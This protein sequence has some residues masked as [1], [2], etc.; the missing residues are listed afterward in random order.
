MSNSAGDGLARLEPEELYG[1]DAELEL[2]YR[3]V[4]SA[5]E[6]ERVV[7]LT[8]EPGSGK[9]ALLDAAAR[10][11]RDAGQRVL[12]GVG[13]EFEADLAFAGLHQLLHPV[14]SEATG[15]LE[16]QRTALLG[17]VGLRPT[18]EVPKPM[19]VGIAVLTLLSDLAERGPLTVVVDDVHWMDRASQ[20]VVAFVARR[21]AEERISLLIGVRAGEVAPGFDRLQR[22][23]VLGPLD[24]GAAHRLVAA[25]AA[26]LTMRGREQII[27]QAAGNPLALQELAQA[28]AADPT[29][30]EAGSAAG[31][32]PLSDR[33]ERIYAAHLEELPQE[34]RAALV[35]LSAA[36]AADPAHDVFAAIPGGAQQW[37]PAYQAGLV[38][39]THER[40]GFRHPL[41]RTAV[42]QRATFQERRAAHL[43]LA[44]A[45]DNE[46]DRQAWHRA[47]AAIQPDTEVATALEHTADR[48]LR[49]GGYAAA[50]AALESGAALSTNRADSARLLVAAA[51]SA[52]YTGDLPWVERMASRV[53]SLT[54]DPTVLSDVSL[55]AG[56]LRAL[57]ANHDAA[58]STLT[59]LAEQALD[60]D[61]ARALD[62]LALASVVCFYSGRTVHRQVVGTLTARVAARTDDVLELWIAVVCDPFRCRTPAAAAL[63][64]LIGSVRHQPDRLVM[65]AIAAALLDE[66]ELAVRTFDEA[67]ALW[68]AHRP[69]PNGLGCTAGLAYLA[70]GRWAQAHAVCAEV[71]SLGDLTGLVHAAACANAVQAMVFAQQGEFEQARNLAEQ[72]LVAVDPEDSRSVAAYARQ[73]LAAAAAAEDD[74][75]SAYRHYR[76]LFDAAGAP[77]HYHACYPALADFAAAAART[78]HGAEAASILDQALE[79]LGDDVSARLAALFSLARARLADPSNAELHFRA[80]L[81]DAALVPFPFE[82]AH[83][84]LA[85]AEWLRRQ[86]RIAQARPLLATAS[87]VFRRLGARPWIEQAKNE[88]RAAGVDV[89]DAV[90]DAIAQLS[91]QQQEIIQLAARGLT[92]REI[93]D[94]LFLSPR[95]VG[96]HLY[97]T[98]PRLG[99]TSRSQLR[100][101]LASR[102]GEP[103]S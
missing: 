20:D 9:S 45:L 1:R 82:R 76:S 92:N 75:E 34:T 46:P 52:A 15:L 37:L 97:R 16:S 56:R 42:Y 99:V 100:D 90:P 65:M 4:R 96:S 74:H 10:C 57:T 14:L 36:D 60:T 71:A 19:E 102:T 69:L 72:A 32:P 66:T 7:L 39:R 87:E 30:L 101:L 78:G 44:A 50:A 35:L 89:A 33:L 103:G 54:D 68:D 62:A 64:A 58:Y 3:V 47:A 17:A 86:R 83:A 88:L 49:R 84:L 6:G 85:Y 24:E 43:R 81:A 77:I 23:A 98:F 8:G 80:A 93:A 31:A 12:H 95:T 67:F 41:I 29:V 38:H 28:A 79:S 2:L 73:A 21:L 22:R 13:S 48:A 91:P 70:H 5:P 63:P 94:R 26:D 11:A 51:G 61:P 40:I 53:F 27:G 59:R 25:Q 18:A 55:I